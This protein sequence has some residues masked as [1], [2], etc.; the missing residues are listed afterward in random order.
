[1]KKII[2]DCERM[3]Y[4]DTGLYHYDLNLS[5]Q[6]NFNKDPDKEEI[7]LY[8]PPSAVHALDPNQSIL[9]QHPL[10][11]F[12]MPSLQDFDIWHGT[13]QSTKYLPMQNRNIKVVLTIHDLNFLYDDKKAEWK[14]QRNLRY[15]QRLIDRSDALVFVSAFT[16]NDVQQRCQLGKLPQF[17][18]YNGSQ[19]SNSPSLTRQSYRPRRPF[20]F[21]IGV[22][23]RKKNFHVLLPLVKNKKYELLIAGKNDDHDYH[24][25][26]LETAKK[27]G[28]SDSVNLLG[29]ITE[30]EKAWYFKHCSAFALPS[31]SEGFGLP[32]VEA[33]QMGKPLFLSNRTSLPEIGGD[34]S[35]YFD[36]FSPDHMQEVFNL[37]L[38]RYDKESLESKIIERATKFSWKKAAQQYLEVYRSLY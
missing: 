28:V 13:Y 9:I 23:N 37:G 34:V 38:D 25:Y 6:L 7:F 19:L 3:K 12:R 11:K 35:F 14:K 17:L 26:I 33:M 1:M 32:V 8:T 31:L 22:I 27:Y 10:H 36:N 30:R 20:L 15:V 2:F 29:S 16:Q 24:S 21:S 18:I 4:P 5:E